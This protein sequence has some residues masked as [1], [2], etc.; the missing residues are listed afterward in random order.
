MSL[1]FIAIGI[2]GLDRGWNDTARR[3]VTIPA[4]AILILDRGLWLRFKKPRRPADK[5]AK[6]P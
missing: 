3:L 4:G 2:F 5:A 1:L 6:R